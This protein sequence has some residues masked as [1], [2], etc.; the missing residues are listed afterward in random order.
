MNASK[1]KAAH[2]AE[3]GAGPSPDD[4][5]AA[6][7]P[8]AAG[9]AEAADAWGHAAVQDGEGER[10]ASDAAREADAKE[11]DA[12]EADPCRAERARAAEWEARALEQE[13]KARAHYDR[14]VRLAA[15]FENYRKRTMREQE[16]QRKYAVQPLAE[17]LL[18]VVDN[19]ERAL[20]QA[21]AY[22]AAVPGDPGA[23]PPESGAASGGSGATP[24]E[25]NAGAG[26]SVAFVEGMTMIHR[27]LLK[28][29]EEVGVTPL[30]TVGRP[31][32]PNVHQ[33][34]GLVPRSE[35]LASGTVAEELQKG[36]MLHDR[37]LRPAMVKV[38]E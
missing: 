16:Q 25:G 19:F 4:A 24:E 23:S 15:E 30:V 8:E 17:R 7:Q 38:V 18:P 21:Q 1:A 20:A 27:Q 5:P 11:A 12:K 14:Y 3:I 37:L 10:A 26:L 6:R 31:F 9:H 29:L 22:A 28:A 33:A 36:Y 2:E 35:G 34:V 32:D 13:L